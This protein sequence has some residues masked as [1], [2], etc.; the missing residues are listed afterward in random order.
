MIELRDYQTAAVDSVFNWDFDQGQPLVVVPTG[1]G[2]SLIQAALIRDVLADAP[3]LVILC[4][5]HLRELIA[6]NHAALCR[7]APELERK[8]GI[9]S[10]GIGQRKVRQITFAGLQTVYSKAEIL[11]RVDLVVVDEAHLIPAKGF[12]MYRTLLE[13]L[14]A[15][16]PDVRLVG[17][18]ATPFR[19]DSGEL[20]KGDGALFG[21][22]SYTVDILDLIDRGFLS[23]LTCRGAAAA[24]DTTGVRRRMGDFIRGELEEAATR[25]DLVERAAA[26]IKLRVE[27]R[28]AGLVFCCGVEHAGRVRDELERLGFRAGLVT[29]ESKKEDRDAATAAIKSGELDC[30][31]NV[32]VLTTGF[33]APH[34]DWIALLRPT[35]SP[36]LYVQMVGRGLRTAEG[37]TDCLVLDFGGNVLRHGPINEVSVRKRSSNGEGDAPPAPQKE[38]E[39]C[40]LIVHAATAVCPDCG[41]EFPAPEPTHDAMPMD[42]VEILRRG[43]GTPTGLQRWNVRDMMCQLHVPQPPKT[44]RSMRVT[45]DCGMRRRVS[46]WV[47]FEHQGFARKKAEQWWKQMAPDTE[48]PATV[49][50]ALVLI[51]LGRLTRRVTQ[52]TVDRRG[53]YPELKGKKLEVDH[54]ALEKAAVRDEQCGELTPDDLDWRKDP[55][56]DLPF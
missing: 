2:K 48:C 19:T 43:D 22:V 30:L 6:Q 35:E 1:G 8:A 38:C 45:Y 34:I 25:G 44:T 32:N 31:C 9:Y 54:D 10:A 33:D 41:F 15:A 13:A 50:M 49:D 14:R 55:F 12:G 11:G 56:A 24:I 20:D 4:V 37:K 47:C 53:D 46:E 5:T 40:H 36:G 16:N 52:V 7:Y 29:G 27:G 39:Q 28:K 3:D 51:E 23:P 18:T 42:G 26:E 21:G 17:L